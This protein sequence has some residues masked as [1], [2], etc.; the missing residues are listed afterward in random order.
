MAGVTHLTAE[1]VIA[2][3]IGFARGEHPIMTTLTGAHGLVV[4]H[5]ADRH[6]GRAHVTGFAH[7]AGEDVTGGFTGGAGAIVA[8]TARRRR[9]AVVKHRH[10]PVGGGMTNLACRRGRN[11][12]AA[13]ACGNHPVMTGYAGAVDLRMI[14]SRIH[15]HPGSKHMTGFAQPGGI[16]MRGR[17][18]G[19]GNPIVA[20]RASLGEARVIKC[21]NPPVDGGM[22]SLA[23]CRGGNMRGA[24]T[25]GNAAIVTG[26]AAA[27]YHVVIHPV[28]RCPCG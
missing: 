17:F 21:G 13:L 11:V 20:G 1:D 3:L 22:T 15:R 14:H 16:N 2:R 10:Q 27:L 19:S 7:I 23:C 18:A 12:V 24:L 4:I 9:G 25:H 8:A 5:R 6:P 28:R 26:F